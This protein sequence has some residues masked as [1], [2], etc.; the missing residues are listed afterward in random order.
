MILQSKHHQDKEVFFFFFFSKRSSHSYL[1][2]N[3]LQP[4]LQELIPL[5]I[6]LNTDWYFQTNVLQGSCPKTLF[7]TKKGIFLP[8]R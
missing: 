5:S 8:I 7:F 1:V 6:L 3:F 4:I 2:G